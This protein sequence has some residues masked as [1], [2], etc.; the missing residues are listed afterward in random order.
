M[1]RFWSLAHIMS[2]A[3]LIK[4]TEIVRAPYGRKVPRAGFAAANASLLCEQQPTLRWLKVTKDVDRTQ[5]LKAS[6]R[7]HCERSAIT[8]LSI[9]SSVD[10]LRFKLAALRTRM[11][12]GRDLPGPLPSTP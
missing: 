2:W 3:D 5:S 12:D 9:G 6:E 8:V 7:V 11:V 1:A 4:W 10:E